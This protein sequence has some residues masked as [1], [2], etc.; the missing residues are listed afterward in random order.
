MFFQSKLKIPS[1]EKYKKENEMSRKQGDKF[2]NTRTTIPFWNGQVTKKMIRQ[3]KSRSSFV[4]R[5]FNTVENHEHYEFDT[6]ASNVQNQSMLDYRYTKL[7]EQIKIMEKMF[8][9]D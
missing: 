7:Q 9:K 8:S 2:Y 6:V 5:A 3:N 1:W 4:K